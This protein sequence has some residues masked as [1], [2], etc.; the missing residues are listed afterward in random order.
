LIEELLDV[1]RFIEILEREWT[2]VI[3]RIHE[4][5][6]EDAVG[7]LR[8]A[9]DW[10]AS[11]TYFCYDRGVGQPEW[12]SEAQSHQERINKTGIKDWTR[13]KVKQEQKVF[14]QVAANIIHYHKNYLPGDIAFNLHD[15]WGFPVDV[16]ED[17][18]P[19]MTVNLAK[20]EHGRDF[21]LSPNMKV[22]RQRFDLIMQATRKMSRQTSK[23]TG[24]VF[25][26]GPLQKIKGKHPKTQ[27]IPWDEY[28]SHEK[29]EPLKILAIISPENKLVDEWSGEGEI[30]IILDRTPFYA[31]AGGQVGDTGVLG[32]GDGSA[33]ARVI[34][35]YS[36]DDYRIHHSVVEK[37]V[38]HVGDNLI[39]C[40]DASRADVQ[41]NH[42]AT[43]LLH[44][45][46]REVLGPKAEQ[47]GSLVEAARLRFDFTHKKAMT[48]EEIARVEEI[49]NEKILADNDVSTRQTTLD[50]AKKDGVIALFGEKYGEKVR[51]VDVGGFSREL[52][53]G[54]HCRRTG[55][56]GLFK[57]VRESSIA[58]GIRRIEA[59]TGRAA[60]KYLSDYKNV[61]ES[62]CK[63]LKTTL[64]KLPERVAALQNEI[65]EL[66]KTGRSP[67]GASVDAEK[68]F[69]TAKEIGGTKVVCRVIDDAPMPALRELV[70]KLKAKE[71]SVAITLGS[72]VGGKVS[73]V[74][75]LSKDLVKRGLKSGELIK[76]IAAVVGG[77]GGG[78]PDMAQAGG[79]DASKLGD[80]I[81]LAEDVLKRALNQ[82]KGQR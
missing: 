5:P 45:A 18:L 34:G 8:S 12:L 10:A 46:L 61:A 60:L 47:S 22:D 64:D 59:V 69:S 16:I 17:V 50:E 21:R 79:K 62:L 25:K 41:R 9:W 71:K 74:V 39:P 40:I 23:F 29:P 77:S 65:R 15:A 28:V 43:H 30:E 48:P 37:G 20:E 1:N 6:I 54:T 2:D 33:L 31:E 27:Y 72:A 38:I 56:I 67:Q 26:A 82:V 55:E 4:D 3:S 81:K 51:V 75:A 44:H 7:Y 76:E 14:Q 53:G 63:T 80:A 68:I 49:V 78:R 32:S 58:S 57:I 66:K 70:D 13:H 35:T 24:I 36:E 11:E 42:T 52:C 73:I 19:Q